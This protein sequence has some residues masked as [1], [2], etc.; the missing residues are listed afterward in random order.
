M[1]RPPVEACLSPDE[2]AVVAELD[3]SFSDDGVELLECIE[4]LVDD[5]LVHMDPEGLGR[6]QLGRIGRRELQAEPL[7]HGRTGARV[8]P[9]QYGQEMF[10]Q[11]S[12]VRPGLSLES[13]MSNDA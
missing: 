5:G 12:I 9:I 13:A 2:I 11:T 7:G 3:A 8:T 10:D 6:L 1:I 4:V